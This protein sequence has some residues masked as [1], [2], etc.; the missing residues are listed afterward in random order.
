MQQ[1]YTIY[2]MSFEISKLEAR[3]QRRRLTFY[4]VPKP[5]VTEIYTKNEADKKEWWDHDG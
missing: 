1:I 4:N 5:F 2:R 3:G